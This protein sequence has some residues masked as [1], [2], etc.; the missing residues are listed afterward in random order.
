VT[1][2]PGGKRLIIQPKSALVQKYMPEVDIDISTPDLRLL[3]TTMTF[4]D[5]SHLK[6]E[7][8]NQQKNPHIDE[9]LFHPVLGPE[10]KITEPLSGGAR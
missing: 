10:Y 2:I 4:V 7:F 5:G 1:P 9:A 8:S 3:A 6:N